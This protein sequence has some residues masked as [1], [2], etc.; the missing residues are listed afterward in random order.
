MLDVHST[1]W[2]IFQNRKPFHLICVWT[3]E[4]ISGSEANTIQTYW[5]DQ[6]TA[7]YRRHFCL[8]KNSKCPIMHKRQIFI[9]GMLVSYL[10]QAKMKEILSLCTFLDKFECQWSY[11]LSYTHLIVPVQSKVFLFSFRQMSSKLVNNRFWLTN[12]LHIVLAQH[13]IPIKLLL[14]GVVYKRLC[15][16]EMLWT[17]IS[18]NRTTERIKMWST[19]FLFKNEA[20][21]RDLHRSLVFKQ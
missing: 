13:K 14:H 16:K 17:S 8:P 3:L 21:H 2:I 9:E 18:C 19:A 4:D 11:P 20:L 6:Y 7:L 1:E 10:S 12:V 5:S 15:L